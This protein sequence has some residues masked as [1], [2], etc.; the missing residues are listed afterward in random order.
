M[1]AAIPM[2]IVAFR[3]YATAP[4]NVYFITCQTPARCKP[5]ADILVTKPVPKRNQFG[6]DILRSRARALYE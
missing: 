5:T 1:R 2:K 6:V 3:N 4:N